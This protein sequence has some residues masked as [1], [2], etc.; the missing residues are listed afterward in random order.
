MADAGDRVIEAP[1]D[2]IR[3][4]LN[5]MT[6]FSTK[7]EVVVAILARLSNAGMRIVD[8]D[9]EEPYVPNEYSVRL[10]VAAW[11]LLNTARV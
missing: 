1:V 6:V 9:G 2:V 3:A 11:R 4:A 10:P 8:V 5:E 7:D